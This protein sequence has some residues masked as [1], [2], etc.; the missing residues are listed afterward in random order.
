MNLN[1]SATDHAASM[2]YV[3]STLSTRTLHH[4]AQEA[5]LNGESLKDAFERYEIDYAW[6]VLGSDRLR[7]ATV[8]SLARRHHHVVT[9]AQRESLAGVLKSAAEAQAPE[10]LMSF[11]ND[12]PDQLADYLLASWG[13]GAAAFA[14]KP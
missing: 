4:F 13:G 7:E 5:K 12:V 2:A 10:L 1:N 14:I 8:D 11:D 9:E 6:Y 3:M